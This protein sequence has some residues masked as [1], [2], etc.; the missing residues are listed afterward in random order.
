MADQIDKFKQNI[1]LISKLRLPG[2]KTKHWGKISEI[3]RFSVIPSM[4]LTLQGF[5]DFDLGRWNIQIAEICSVA[6]QKYNNESS[7]Y[8]MDAE[9]QTKQ[10][11]THEFR[12]TGSYILFDVDDIFSLIDDQLVTTQTLLTSP[13]IAPVKKKALERLSF[14]RNAHETHDQLVECQRRWLYLQTIFTG[15]SIQHKLFK[16]ARD[17]YNVDNTWQSIMTLTHN[18]TDFTNVIHRDN[19]LQDLKYS[20]ELL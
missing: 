2:I 19:L 16:E 12:N 20:N 8:Q 17:W 15:T 5:L 9:L 1:P 13:F 6:A 10:F 11:V 3:V 18:H 14:L 4:E 7:L